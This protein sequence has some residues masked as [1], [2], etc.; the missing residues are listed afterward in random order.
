VEALAANLASDTSNFWLDSYEY[1]RL[2]NLFTN[3]LPSVK[4]GVRR[5]RN[6]NATYIS[7][8]YSKT[9]GFNSSSV[10]AGSV[11]ELDIP[12]GGTGQVKMLD[13]NGNEVDRAY[14][15]GD[16]SVEVFGSNGI[17]TVSVDSI[18]VS[19][20]VP[21][22]L[23]AESAEVAVGDSV[24]SVINVSS[25]ALQT[26]ITSVPQRFYAGDAGV[27]SAALLSVASDIASLLSTHSYDAATVRLQNIL[28]PLIGED[29]IANGQKLSSSD[30]TKE[31]LTALVQNL[32]VRNETQKP[33]ISA[34][35]GAFVNLINLDATNE[36][37]HPARIEI[38]EVIEPESKDLE[39]VISV[40]L[41]GV[42]QNVEKHGKTWLLTT[43]ALSPGLHKIIASTFLRSISETVKLQRAVLEMRQEIISLQTRLDDAIDPSFRQQLEGQI[44]ILEQ[45]I[46]VLKNKLS[47]LQTKV[48]SDV[49]IDVFAS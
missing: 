19:I 43:G 2:Y 25:S 41:D 30:V 22:S 7:G 13:P 20:M 27:Q 40:S 33:L 16:F 31:D 36:T 5:V 42:L 39:Q 12:T 48:G 17:R 49:E 28:L 1:L 46:I 32:I 47:S 24:V 26:A 44:T 6:S 35:K 34:P 8:S 14:F 23:A 4:P 15:D 45:R 38:Q 9:S 10:L 29:L 3:Q 37:G 18:P 11:G 21:S